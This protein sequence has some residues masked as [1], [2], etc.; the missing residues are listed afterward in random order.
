MIKILRKSLKYVFIVL[1][2]VYGLATIFFI[3]DQNY[4][5]A[6]RNLVFS[7]LCYFGYRNQREKIDEK[8]KKKDELENKN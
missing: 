6:G 4:L 3:V 5:I 7:V 8:N 2:V 1:T